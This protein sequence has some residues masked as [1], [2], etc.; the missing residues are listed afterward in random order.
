MGRKPPECPARRRGE[1][2]ESRGRA[3]DPRPNRRPYLSVT[4]KI[5]RMTNMPDS[6]TEEFLSVP[7]EDIE[8]LHNIA[9]RYGV[10]VSES[11]PLGIEVVSTI[12]VALLGS[13]LAV[14]TVRRLLEER[15]GGQVI[16]MR[17]DAGRAVFRSRDVQ[18]GLIVVLAADGTVTVR[19]TDS[20][21][22]LTPVI[23]SLRGLTTGVGGAS[24]GAVEQAVRG[25]LGS[26]VEI[27]AKPIQDHKETDRRSHEA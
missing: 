20:K 14:N 3:P 5:P 7:A 27:T 24:V 8:Y 16:D 17:P 2:E 13:A 23:E 6:L 12:A 4:D 10:D 1:E 11:K 18:Y 25:R 22:E 21:D 19:A 9:D 15:K 26:D